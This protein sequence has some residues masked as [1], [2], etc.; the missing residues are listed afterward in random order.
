LA[1]AAAILVGAFAYFASL[2]PYGLNVDD[3]GTLLYQIYRTYVG[4]LLYVDFHAGYTPGIFFA[5]AALFALAGVNVVVLRLGLAVVNALSV[6]CLY[7]LARRLGTG[8]LSA[9]AGGLSFLALIPFY[10][11]QF[12]AFN[13]P[14]PIWYVTLFWLLAV[15]SVIGWLRHRQPKWWWLAGLS[16]GVV[17]SFKPNSGLLC[18]AGVLIALVRLQQA[19][20]NEVA[21]RGR[22]TRLLVLLER[23]LRWIIP[24]GLTLALTMFYARGAGFREVWL[25]ALPLLLFVGFQLLRS[26][27][28]YTVAPLTLW[29]E[30][31]RLG[32]GFAIVV[33]PW[34][35]YFWDK[36]GTRP[37]LRAILF[38]GTG[39]D[40][41]YYMPHPPLGVWGLALVVLLGGAAVVAALLR[42]RWLPRWLVVTALVLGLGSMVGVWSL[43][44]PRMVEGLQSSV[45]MRVRD[46]AFVMVLAVEWASLASYAVLVER[47]RRAAQGSSRTDQRLAVFSV[48]AVSAVLMHMQLYP[49]SDFMHLVPACPL[50]LVLGAWLLDRF[51]RWCAAGLASSRV[52]QIATAGAVVLPLYLLLAILLLPA[53]RRIDYMLRAWRDGDTTAVVR[54]ASE[55]APLVVEP[56]AARMFDSLSATV[57][58]LQAHTRPGEA[59]FTFPVLDVLCFLADRHN[60]TRHGYFFPGWPGHA[61]EAE[62][63]DAL[64]ERPPR[65]IVTLHQHSLFFATAPVYFFN[66]R[67]YVLGNY[68]LERRIGLLDVLRYAPGAVPQVREADG[69]SLAARLPAWRSELAHHRGATARRLERALL[70]P[71]AGSISG[72]ADIIERIDPK[73]QR[74][75]VLLIRKSRSV[76]GVAALA[77]LVQRKHLEPIIQELSIRTVAE[78]GDVRSVPALLRGLDAAEPAD[79][80]AYAGMLYNVANKLSLENYW[81]AAALRPELPTIATML[82]TVSLVQWLDNPW[83]GFALRS[84]AIRIAGRVGRVETLPFLARVLGDAD[85][86]PD[87]RVQ[88]AESLAELGY[89]VEMLAPTLGLL[90]HDSVGPAALAAS[91]YPR[92]PA[93][94]RPALLNLMVA[95]IDLTRATAFW[96]AAGVRDAGLADNLRQGL[97][98]ELPEIRM[99]AAWGLGRLGDAAAAPA[100]RAKLADPNDEVVWFVSDALMRLESGVGSRE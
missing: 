52:A 62:V 28:P 40:K 27:P 87:L 30:L 17:F 83:E 8:R 33:L 64:E 70:E 53:L 78:L 65:Y 58:Y 19:D 32:C 60:P 4:E 35:V 15:L 44:A 93:A 41:F 73:Q 68:R 6:L 46:V 86:W 98:D 23:W 85:E 74:L 14:Y 48:V 18:L 45:V 29:R 7:L 43:H 75:M 24:L 55:R 20:R 92:A 36:L 71:Q 49:R 95:P 72:L 91:T 96:L 22:L 5:N 34:S 25:F 69:T 11:G 90:R 2:A 67:Q 47:R 81:Y 38:V 88:A 94:G 82:D 42:R 12:A 16:A 84:F 26:P 100:L 57:E 63:I 21:G 61:V 56:G 39:F 37:F 10:D 97:A 9:A 99:A 51:A 77:D 89:A 50:M 79:R 76:G 66:L 13:I 54:L 31:I 3:E 1:T 59:V 80:E